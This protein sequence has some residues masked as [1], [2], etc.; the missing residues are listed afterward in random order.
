MMHIF[1]LGPQAPIRPVKP[2]V[3][4]DTPALA[5]GA[6]GPDD[7]EA[8]FARYTQQYRGYLR[9]MDSYETER[10]KWERE[11]GGGAIEIS[12]T[13]ANIVECGRGRY[14]AELPE[15]VTLGPRSGANR[16]IH[17]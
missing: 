9:A 13:Q 1:D 5:P 15:G 17:S 8:E 3:L 14:V 2:R 6:T 16:V 10:A 11:S 4:L 7:Y 12:T